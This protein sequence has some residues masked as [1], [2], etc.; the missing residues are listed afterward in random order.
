MYRK[1]PIYRYITITYIRQYLE[2]CITQTPLQSIHSA[3]DNRIANGGM[4]FGKSN[5][6]KLKA[7]NE[8]INLTLTRKVR[9]GG[10][11]LF[12]FSKNLKKGGFCFVF[13]NKNSH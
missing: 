2:R 10:F 11:E 1:I 7:R 3:L 4:E 12:F 6:A 13:Q 8:T 5:I 9:K